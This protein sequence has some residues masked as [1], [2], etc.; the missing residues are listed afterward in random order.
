[1]PLIPFEARLS[2][3]RHK[4]RMRARQ[5]YELDEAARAL[6]SVLSDLPLQFGMKTAQTY[7]HQAAEK[8]ITGRG[9]EPLS[10]LAAQFRALLIDL[11]VFPNI[12]APVP[13]DWKPSAKGRGPTSRPPIAAQF[14]MG[15][16]R[17]R[18]DTIRPYDLDQAAAALAQVR[19]LV[20]DRFRRQTAQTLL[21]EAAQRGITGNE[22]PEA[23]D[24]VAE[25]RA[26]LIDI[27]IFPDPATESGAEEG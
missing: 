8:G 9:S 3:D 14:R 22:K 21:N 12:D 1:V 19:G 16:W 18:L 24:I 10:P 2:G 20:P 11:E 15:K 13:S 4:V 26:R 17:V 5:Y 7:L 25:Y 23:P 27:G 6:A